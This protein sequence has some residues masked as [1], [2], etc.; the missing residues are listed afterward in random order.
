MALAQ[1]MAILSFPIIIVFIWVRCLNASSDFILVAT[2]SSGECDKSSKILLPVPAAAKSTGGRQQEVWTVSS[3]G[4]IEVRGQAF[5]AQSLF[6]PP[7]QADSQEGT[8]L[9][10]SFFVTS[11]KH[12][13]ISYVESIRDELSYKKQ[14]LYE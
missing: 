10:S 12:N 4:N 8:E 5:L 11:K 7:H 1:A 6:S 3:E 13:H 2:K 9:F 14:Y